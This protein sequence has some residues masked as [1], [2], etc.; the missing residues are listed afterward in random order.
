MHFFIWLHSSTAFSK[1]CCTAASAQRQGGTMPAGLRALDLL[2]VG[3]MCGTMVQCYTRAHM[4]FSASASTAVGSL[5]HSCTMIACCS[6]LHQKCCKYG[7]R[8]SNNEPPV[9]HLPLEYMNTSTTSCT[10]SAQEYLVFF[11]QDQLRITL[12]RNQMSHSHLS[13]VHTKDT[14][15]QKPG[16]QATA[17]AGRPQSKPTLN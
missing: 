17:R 12:F 9:V 1:I 2:A 15:R 14:L 7:W 4:L 11:N 13:P 16:G 5:L 8:N 10:A 3:L 6:P